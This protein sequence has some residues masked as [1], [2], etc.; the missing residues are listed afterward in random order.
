MLTMFKYGIITLLTGYAL[1]GRSFAY[2]GLS[3]IYIGEFVLILGFVYFIFTDGWKT[4][5]R[6]PLCRLLVLFMIWG[7][8]RTFPYIS[9][10]GIV[11]LRD[12]ASWG[13]GIFALI[14]FS[15][16]IKN[17]LFESVIR[18]YS[19]MIPLFL[20]WMP[21]AILISHFLADSMP[22]LPWG[23]NNSIPLITTKGGDISVHLAGIV[24]FYFIV[25][26]YLSNRKLAL[27]FWPSWSFC[28]LLIGFTG[29]AAILTVATAI[30][31]TIIYIKPKRWVKGV[32]FILL[33][34]GFM[35]IFNIQYD[36]GQERTVSFEQLV[37]NV[38]S[39]FTEVEGF[40][41]EGTKMWRI[42]WWQKI[43]DYTVFGEY[44]WLGKGFG[45]N[46]ADDDGF[47]VFEDS[48]LR[49]PHNGHLT[50]L[51]RA[52]VPG[53]LLWIALQLSF[54]ISLFKSYRRLLAR[55]YSQDASLYIWLLIYWLAFM[56]N[57][58]FDVFFEGPQ[59]GIWFW[60]IIGLG[61]GLI[62]MEKHLTQSERSTH[63][64]FTTEPITEGYN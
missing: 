17:Q 28:F 44:F 63:H 1:F 34:I 40:S 42:W 22:L 50:F 8:I 56:V 24:S 57:G 14:I 6:E 23:P 41:G 4:I 49:S 59:G 10:Y 20:L 31:A 45:I 5:L 29:R 53:F 7:A 11:A 62:Y 15:M 54:A 61:F 13:Y 9:E 37:T 47:Q 19:R 60:S 3:P 32:A 55:G 52:G 35:A 27:L 46:L 2:I 43:I 33:I 26:P 58:A 12:G 18:W 30:I 25:L 64:S 36:T 16:L 51:A 21:L 48:S 38:K 39:I